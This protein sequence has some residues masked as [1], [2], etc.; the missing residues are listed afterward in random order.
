MYLLS[1]SMSSLEKYVINS[2]AHFL[3]RFFFFLLLSYISSF[4]TLDI[5]LYQLYDLQISYSIQ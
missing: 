1:I 5:K 3:I 2:S 4:F